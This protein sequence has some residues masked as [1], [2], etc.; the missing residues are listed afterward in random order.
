MVGHTHE[1][2]DRF[3]SYISRALTHAENT[4]TG[5]ALNAL[6]ENYL[7]DGTTMKV[8]EL[9]WV[10]DWKKWFQ[11]CSEEMHDHT[12][13][14]SALHWRFERDVDDPEGPVKMRSKHLHSDP[15]WVPKEG[16][17][18][19]KKVPDGLVE[20]APYHPL[21]G[22]V[23]K[24]SVGGDAQ[25]KKYMAQLT[26]TKQLLQQNKFLNDE[27]ELKWWEDTL[28]REMPDKNQPTPVPHRYT[29]DSEFRQTFP[30]RDET[31]AVLLSTLE[32][33]RNP[34]LTE[35]ER[36]EFGESQR[37]EPYIGKRMARLRRNDRAADPSSMQAGS[38]V[39]I[40]S[41]NIAEPFVFG[42]VTEVFLE[43][44]S[45]NVHWYTRPNPEGTDF[46]QVFS[47]QWD[48]DPVAP[49]RAKRGSRQKKRKT[50]RCIGSALFSNIM[51]FDLVTTARGNSQFLL[52]QRA[53]SRCLELSQNIDWGNLGDDGS[54]GASSGESDD[55][56]RRHESVNDDDEAEHDDMEE[57]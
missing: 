32:E 17:V 27:T 51:C 49:K 38:V 25:H 3:F 53:Q 2:V 6:I 41:D 47:E 14:G 55:E 10:G 7:E 42:K 8:D 30:T 16:L 50:W 29:S 5:D 21:G 44:K 26:K 57:G 4:M 22:G 31:I 12:G 33:G 36:F 35:N 37:K 46:N 23:G 15:L 20:A 13:K 45:F 11:G 24:K 48:T 56:E 43:T 1:A 19:V 18:L 39:M 9:D 54:Q 40:L 28:A 34:I 52:T